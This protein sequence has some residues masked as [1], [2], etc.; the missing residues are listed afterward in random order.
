MKIKAVP[1]T[2]AGVQFRSTLEA[3]WAA[4]LDRLAVS[5][6]YEPEAIE[7]PSGALYRPDFW[8]PALGCW[9]EVKGPGVPGIEKAEEL[10]AA[11]H[12]VIRGNPPLRGLVDWELLPHPSVPEATW[13]NRQRLLCAGFC[14]PASLRAHVMF[15][16]APR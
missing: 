15:V 1:Q 4:T 16:R 14:L 12:W 10:A 8:L 9:L 7:L 5:W 11:G 13:R 3:D 6:S 2:Y